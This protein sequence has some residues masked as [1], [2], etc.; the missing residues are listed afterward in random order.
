MKESLATISTD[1]GEYFTTTII[2]NE[3]V[4]F[5]KSIVEPYADQLFSCREAAT[6]PFY[7][8]ICRANAVSHG[9]YSNKLVTMVVPSPPKRELLFAA[10][11]NSGH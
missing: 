11:S 2:R 7:S 10:T 6:Y 3:R 1:I 5:S 8:T 9:A 4:P